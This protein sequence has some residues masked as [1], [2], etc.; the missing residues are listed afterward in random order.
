MPPHELIRARNI[1]LYEDEQGRLAVFKD[2]G[3]DPSSQAQT[4]TGPWGT[5]SFRFLQ[6]LEPSQLPHTVQRQC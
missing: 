2:V 1:H 6:E 5:P 3:T 4:K